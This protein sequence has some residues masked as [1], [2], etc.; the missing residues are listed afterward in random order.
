L[1]AGAGFDKPLP[2][3]HFFQDKT[4]PEILT[5]SLSIAGKQQASH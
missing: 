4:G 3:L 5:Y 1:G 2:L